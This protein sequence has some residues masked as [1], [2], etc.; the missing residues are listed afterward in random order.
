ML[1]HDF[2]LEVFKRYWLSHPDRW[3]DIAL[4]TYQHLVTS[5]YEYEI[6]YHKYEKL[7][8][9]KNIQIKFN[10]SNNNRTD[11]INKFTL[12]QQSL[13]LKL[14]SATR[15]IEKLELEN[16]RLR[17]LITKIGLIIINLIP[18]M[19][20]QMVARINALIDEIAEK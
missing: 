2:Q 13:K 6:L 1:Q 11:K 7:K 14:N 15:I 17:S 5:H 9:S 8:N 10:Y 20:K 3:E 19:P 4:E 18:K 12:Q 16:Q